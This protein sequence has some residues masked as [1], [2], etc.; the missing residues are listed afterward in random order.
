MKTIDPQAKG[1]YEAVLTKK[2]VPPTLRTQYLKWLRYYLDFC[3]KYQ[4]E[5]R[6]RLSFSPFARKLKDKHQTEQ[7]RK[8]AL[9]AVSIFYEIQERDGDQDSLPVLKNTKTH[10]SRKKDCPIPTN[11][12]WTSTFNGLESEIKIRHYSPKTLTA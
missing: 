7:Q 1:L 3:S 11:A 10:L 4:H 12:D 9:D 5:P 8:Q 6:N 2:N